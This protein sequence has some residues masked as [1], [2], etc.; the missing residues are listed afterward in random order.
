MLRVNA[1]FES[2]WTKMHPISCFLKDRPCD[3]IIRSTTDFTGHIEIID[4]GSKWMA[5]D[6]GPDYIALR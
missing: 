2:N 4:Q 3:K 5:I 1:S 6:L